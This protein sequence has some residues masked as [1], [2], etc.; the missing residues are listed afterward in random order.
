MPQLT[1]AEINALKALRAEAWTYEQI[2][3]AFGVNGRVMHRILTIPGY[4]LADRSLI[5]IRRA[6]SERQRDDKPT[7]RRVRAEERESV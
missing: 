6:F 1:A 7:R 3:A 5:K 4:R 2:G